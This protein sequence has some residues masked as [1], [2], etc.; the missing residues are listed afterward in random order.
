MIY[1]VRVYALP[2]QPT[3]ADR[4]GLVAER[5][6]KARRVDDAREAG[7]EEGKKHGAIRSVNLGKLEGG[8]PA[9]LVY[10]TRGR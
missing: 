5:D 9:V 6:V 1:R 4:P 3:P 8:A 2:A 10:V 7:R